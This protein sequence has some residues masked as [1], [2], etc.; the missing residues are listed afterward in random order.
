MDRKKLIVCTV[1]FAIVVIGIAVGAY[2]ITDEDGFSL[3]YI[4]SAII[5]GIWLSK[6]IMEFYVWLTK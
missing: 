4:V 6:K 3:G 5:S 1:L 2:F